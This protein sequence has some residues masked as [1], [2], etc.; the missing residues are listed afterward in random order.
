M[1]V[2]RSAVLHPAR[3]HVSRGIESV[4]GS[5]NRQRLILRIGAVC[6]DVP[7]AASVLLPSTGLRLGRGGGS[8]TQPRRMQGI[9]GV[10]H[11]DAQAHSR[12]ARGPREGCRTRRERTPV[13]EDGFGIARPNLNE[14][15]LAHVLG[16]APSGD[17][18]RRRCTQVRVQRI[19]CPG[20]G[21]ASARQSERGR[22]VF[23]QIRRFVSGT[24]HR[25]LDYL[26][27]L[28]SLGPSN[29]DGGV[30]LRVGVGFFVK[31]QRGHGRRQHN[32]ARCLAPEGE[33]RHPL[34][35]ECALRAAVRG[36]AL[37]VEL[38][39]HAAA[40]D[41]VADVA[42]AA[43]DHAQIA[44]L[45]PQLERIHAGIRHALERGD[46]RRNNQAGQLRAATERI[47]T[48][49]REPSQ[50]GAQVHLGQ[51]EIVQEGIVR[52]RGRTTQVH[53]SKI[54]GVRK[55]P[56][57]DRLKRIRQG[58]RREP[59]A[60]K[61]V[62]TD[63]A[64]RGRQRHRRNG[65]TRERVVIDLRDPTNDC[66]GHSPIL[67]L[68]IG[69]QVRMILR[70]QDTVDA[71]VVCVGSIDLDGSERASSHKGRHQL[72]RT[73]IGSQA[74]RREPTHPRKR[75]VADRHHGARQR[76]GL[77]SR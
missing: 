1:V 16:A 29:V 34:A 36:T 7:P 61:R 44:H 24:L 75:V 76:Q 31:L 51:R 72:V 32:D 49:R 66:V 74:D 30:R 26:P 41:N 69:N 11:V 68:R 9:G 33:R 28:R 39:V 70:I 50:L 42:G 17:G 4:H 2:P 22:G 58:H 23:L 38:A 54:R 67:C 35:E 59:R 18:H 21:D 10:A 46:R 52:H 5:A 15:R 20:L 48:D 12:A 14:A 19:P 73:N 56:G 57:T 8:D 13:L 47:V 65:R 45:L 27:G 53:P 43:R 40:Y 63:R 55:R 6:V 25:C 62:V 64:Q 37:G 60:F 77:Q 3:A 71:R